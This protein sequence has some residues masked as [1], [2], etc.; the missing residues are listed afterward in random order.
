MLF[1]KYRIL[2]AMGTLVSTVAGGEDVYA[3]VGLKGQT[4]QNDDTLP[5]VYDRDKDLIVDEQDICHNSLSS[6]MKNIYGCKTIYE[7]TQRIERYSGFLFDGLSANL[8]Q[9]GQKRLDDLIK[10][11]KPYGFENIKLDI[12]GN[13]D[14]ED[15]TKEDAL[16]LSQ[17]RAD[18]I[19]EKM[20]LAGAIGTKITTHP[21]G[22]DAPMFSNETSD[23]IEKN[24]RVDIVVRKLKK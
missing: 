23:A 2:D 3:N 4:P 18:T 12:I 22:T 15:I 20:L 8:T 13:V 14:D 16:K 6:D 7:D 9:E 24:N 17:D 19:R 10:Q 11:I 21:E 1:A 5:I